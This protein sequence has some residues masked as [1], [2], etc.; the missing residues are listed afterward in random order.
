MN[1][2]GI[3]RRVP[4]RGPGS[5]AGDLLE[6]RRT[7]P[8]GRSLFPRPRDGGGCF[9]AV[10]HRLG[11]G[12]ALGGRV[13]RRGRRLPHG[14][15]GYSPL[16]PDDGA[17]ES[18]PERWSERSAGGRCG[19]ARR[20]G[21]RRRS[22]ARPCSGGCPRSI[23]RYI[24]PIFTSICA[25]GSRA[26]PGTAVGGAVPT[27]GPGAGPARDSPGGLGR[28]R[29]RPAFLRV[30]G[31]SPAAATA[32]DPARRMGLPQ[33]RPRSSMAGRRT[34]EPDF[35]R[36]WP[37]AGRGPPARSGTSPRSAPVTGERSRAVIRSPAPGAG[38]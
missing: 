38:R 15:P 24:R 33:D 36:A 35:G 7:G 22:S 34:I 20:G 3:I 29:V 31:I 17:E 5:G 10:L 6:H 30:D 16:Q 14:L 9:D 21:W 1:D 37:A 32:S 8:H 2:H 26:G 27:A 19:A 18:V 12:V 11:A 28:E 25:R 13:R 4:D 23:W